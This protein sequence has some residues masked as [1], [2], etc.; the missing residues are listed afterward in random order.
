MKKL[1][2]R[3][4]SCSNRGYIEV[5]E[6]AVEKAARGVFAVNVSEGIACEHSFVVYIDKNL[7]VRDSFIADFQLVLP[8]ISS[9]Q[10]KEP[11]ISPQLESID[12]SLIKLNLTGS[13]LV[14]VIRAI[15]LRKKILILTDQIFMT[16]QIHNFF[17]Y[18]M[19]DSFEVSILVKTEERDKTE[20]FKD[21]I[22][23]KGNRIIQDNNDILKPKKIRIERSLVR[24][25]LEEYELY[26][27]MISLRERIQD[28]YKISETIVKKIKS[29]KKKEKLIPKNVIEEIGYIHKIEIQIPYLEFLYEIVENYFKIQV[30]RFNAVSDFLE[31]L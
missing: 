30:P 29:L 20:S 31:S 17:K 12:V 18:I 2:V 9:P 19:K 6:E 15:F 22:V 28:A 10:V 4:P 8:E 14:N 11:Y 1:E 26:P 7:S 25:F 21:F 5:S 24:K 3:C 27:S 23:L 16:D 13:L